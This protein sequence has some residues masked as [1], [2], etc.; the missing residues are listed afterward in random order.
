MIDAGSEA[1]T[2]AATGGGADE[3]TPP[4]RREQDDCESDQKMSNNHHQSLCRGTATSPPRI[5][6]ELVTILRPIEVA[7]LVTVAGGSSA[8]RG[9]ANPLATAIAGITAAGWIVV[10]LVP[11]DFAGAAGIAKQQTEDSPFAEEPNS[12]AARLAS[13]IATAARRLALAAR[14]NS[15]RGADSASWLAIATR[16]HPTG[17]FATAARFAATAGVHVTALWPC[18]NAIGN[19]WRATSLEDLP[20]VGTAIAAIAACRTTPHAAVA[21]AANA[22]QE[23]AAKPQKRIAGNHGDG[24]SLA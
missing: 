4:L 24:L 12:T 10:P 9:G 1:L 17:R 18:A 5:D 3:L 19:M 11:V 8:L 22:Q 20:R 21:A 6:T 13:R 23:R 15:A 16:L 2:L 14:F 7:R